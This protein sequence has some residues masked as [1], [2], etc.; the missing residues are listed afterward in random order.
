MKKWSLP[1]FIGWKNVK[2]FILL[3]IIWISVYQKFVSREYA[4]HGDTTMNHS[5]KKSAVGV[6][7]SLLLL[8]IMED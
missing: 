2:L 7:R 8:A 5:R 1:V 3:A 4:P 6:S